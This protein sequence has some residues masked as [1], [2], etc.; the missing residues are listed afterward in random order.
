MTAEDWLRL[1]VRTAREHGPIVDPAGSAPADPSCE[2]SK[3]QRG[4]YG[5]VV[6]AD[7]GADNGVTL[8]V[9]SAAAISGFVMGLLVRGEGA[10]GFTSAVLAFVLI[11]LGWWLRG[12]ALAANFPPRA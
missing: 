4:E 3:G 2:A 1:S 7:D 9:M 12:A 10:I 6:L 11:W 8:A 5:G